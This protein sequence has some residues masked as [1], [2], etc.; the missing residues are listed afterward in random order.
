MEENN[1]EHILK[2]A[3][4]AEQ[5]LDLNNLPDIEPFKSLSMIVVNCIYSLRA[6]Y[7]TILS[8]IMVDMFFLHI[9][10]LKINK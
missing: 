4:F 10:S 5:N 3:T 9:I 2:F 8:I 7:R 1:K 6:N